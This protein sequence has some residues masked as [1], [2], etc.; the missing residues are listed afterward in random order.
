MLRYGDNGHRRRDRKIETRVSTS[1]LLDEVRFF[2]DI[3]HSS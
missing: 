3:R 2:D 1:R